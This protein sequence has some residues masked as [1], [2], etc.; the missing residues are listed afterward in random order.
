MS[1]PEGSIGSERVG[2]GGVESGARRG[3]RSGETCICGLIYIEREREAPNL[4]RRSLPKKGA[5]HE[6]ITKKECE[7]RKPSREHE[8]EG[9]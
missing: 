9:F 5:G 3:S 7:R 2:K 1:Q 6:E 8:R 4:C